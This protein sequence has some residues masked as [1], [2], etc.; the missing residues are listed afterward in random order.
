MGPLFVATCYWATVA[1]KFL[2][3]I[4]NVEKEEAEEEEMRKAWLVAWVVLV[5][6]CYTGRRYF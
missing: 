3:C 6:A 5:S 2:P 4:S 1:Y